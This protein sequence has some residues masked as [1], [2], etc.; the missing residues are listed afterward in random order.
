MGRLVIGPAAALALVAG[1][2]LASDAGVWSELWVAIPL[3]ILVAILG[4]SGAVLGPT[5]NRLIELS[6]GRTDSPE[7]DAAF[8]RIMTLVTGVAVGVLVA[9]FFMVTKLDA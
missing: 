6:S 4:V 9:I 5:E 7:Y 1:V 8:G 3:L 2:Y